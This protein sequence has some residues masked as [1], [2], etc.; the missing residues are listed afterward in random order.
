MVDPYLA[1]VV[2]ERHWSRIDD[3]WAHLR[4]LLAADLPDELFVCD[5][6]P[7]LGHAHGPSWEQGSCPWVTRPPAA[8]DARAVLE[9]EDPPCHM[10]LIALDGRSWVRLLGMLA[11]VQDALADPAQAPASQAGWN[12]MLRSIDNWGATGPELPA[13]MLTTARIVLREL[14]EQ[15]A[16][17]WAAA[18][19][20]GDCSAAIIEVALGRTGAELERCGTALLNGEHVLVRRVWVAFVDAVRAGHDPVAAGAQLLP[21]RAGLIW[22]WRT[23]LDP[24]LLHHQL[25]QAAALLARYRDEAAAEGLVVS[26]VRYDDH[27]LY[28]EPAEGMSDCRAALASCPMVL[29]PRNGTALV[30][31][32]PGLRPSLQGYADTRFGRSRSHSSISR[33]VNTIGPA[34]P[35]MTEELLELAVTL[36]QGGG[37]YLGC[38][39]AALY[40]TA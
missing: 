5:E 38:V 28:E 40:V 22:R 33:A 8:G 26:W 9:R 3:P 19:R 17:R 24:A 16:Q 13:S 6:E 18:G 39:D 31:H 36:Y 14:R 7:L 23:G 25:E 30:V 2:R 4:H 32:P 11:H 34:T 15:V 12:G 1:R 29:H 35:L 10:C 37:P 27:H 20:T 21:R